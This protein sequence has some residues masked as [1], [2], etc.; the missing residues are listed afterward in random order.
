MNSSLKNPLLLLLAATCLAL[1]GWRVFGPDRSSGLQQRRDL[2]DE[3]ARWVAREAAAGGAGPLLILAPVDTARDPFPG[4]LARRAEEHLRQAGF[5]PV[6][7]ERVPYSRT[8]ESTGEPVEMASFLAVLHDHP[9]CATVLSLVGIPRLEAASIPGS[10]RRRILV[11]ST[12]RMPYLDQIPPGVVELVIGVRTNSAENV[13]GDP[14][15]GELGRYFTLK[16]Q[17]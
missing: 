7:V 5:G 17:P 1:A 9:E 2:A 13:A 15:L 6:V 16:R 14:A 10:S 3:L 11:A 8:L 12:I 4:A